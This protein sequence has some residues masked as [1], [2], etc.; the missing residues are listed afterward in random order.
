MESVTS[1]RPIRK[2]ASLLFHNSV[3]PILKTR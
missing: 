3:G 1:P 2:Q